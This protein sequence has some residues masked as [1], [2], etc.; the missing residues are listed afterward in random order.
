MV[1]S[2]HQYWWL[3]VMRGMLAVIFG[4]VA[5]SVPVFLLGMVGITYGLY[6]IGDGLMVTVTA[7]RYRHENVAW[8]VQLLE[9]AAGI[10]AGAAVLLIPE[11]ADTALVFII[12]YWAIFTGSME[13]ISAFRLRRE[14]DR[15]WS[16]AIGGALSIFLGIYILLNPGAGLIGLLWMIGSYAV[17]FGLVIVY[18]GFKARRFM[19]QFTG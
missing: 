15:E 19:H 5:F 10:A 14:I 3:L 6:A 4:I 11:V 16:L 2:F 1:R 18:F 8:W 13:M 9:G 17:L 7:L 12:A